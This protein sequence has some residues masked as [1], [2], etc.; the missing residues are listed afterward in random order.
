MK[1]AQLIAFLVCATCIA[2]LSAPVH[3]DRQA[4]ET[5]DA[6]PPH[7]AAQHRK[8]LTATHSHNRVAFHD[9]VPFSFRGIPLGITLVVLR[10]TDT[11]R[12]T[13]HESSLVCETDVAGG[14]LGMMLKSDASP[15]VACRWAHR[16]PAGWAASQAVVAGAPAT[17]H[18]LR[19]ARQS[20]GE[21]LRLYEMSFVVDAM[22]AFDMRNALASH[23][24]APRLSGEPTL[25]LLEWRNAWSTITICLLPGG[26]RAT[27]TYQLNATST[28]AK[29]LDRT[30]KTSQFDEG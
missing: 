24:G 1:R 23:Y 10:D 30:M 14:D 25:P 12:A 2:A 18:V 22:T 29:G 11:V 4:G 16:T 6:A 26:R 8:A 13:P 19:F 17:D 28:D 27:L 20:P 9:D 21:P 15:T 5:T 3:A 7:V